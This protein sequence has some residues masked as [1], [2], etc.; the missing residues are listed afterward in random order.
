MSPI[1]ARHARRVEVRVLALELMASLRPRGAGSSPSTGRKRALACAATARRPSSCRSTSVRREHDPDEVRDT[2]LHEIAHALVGPGHGHD[3]VWKAKCVEV[4]AKPEAAAATPTCP[5]A[6]GRRRARSAASGSRGTAGRSGCAAEL[7]RRAGRERGK[8]RRG[9]W[10][11]IPPGR[12]DLLAMPRR[13]GFAG[14]RVVFRPLRPFG[15]QR[16]R[17]GRA[18]GL[19]GGHTANAAELMRRR[20]GTGEAAEEAISS[21]PCL[22]RHVTLADPRLDPRHRARAESLQVGRRLFAGRRTPPIRMRAMSLSTSASVA[23]GCRAEPLPKEWDGP[24]RVPRPGPPSRRRRARGSSS[25]KT[26]Q[27]SASGS[28]RA[29]PR[30]R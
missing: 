23:P 17:V 20:M 21:R 27:A 4:G 29:C 24:R 2:I 19:H 25:A 11:Q 16:P 14:Q 9:G 13:P 28:S 18:D 22:R 7:Q 10:S 6:G 15:K 8:I 26:G 3:A 12:L 30:V 1:A 5:R